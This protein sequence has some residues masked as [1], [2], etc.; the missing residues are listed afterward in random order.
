M[1]DQS[2]V[3]TKEDIRKEYIKRNLKYTLT[4][5]HVTEAL[6]SKEDSKAN[7]EDLRFEYNKSKSEYSH[8]GLRSIS[9]V[10]WKKEP[11]KSDSN[12]ALSLANDYTYGQMLAK[13]SQ[14]GQ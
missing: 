1:I 11:S 2:I 9:Y 3:I 8:E 7:D 14:S 5:A 4:G 12:S 10:S 13:T 6:V